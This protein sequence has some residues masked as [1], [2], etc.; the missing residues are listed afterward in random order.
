MSTEAL[1]AGC[2]G[3]VG[4]GI[5]L[6]RLLLK[7][8]VGVTV[9]RIGPRP[10]FVPPV[11]WNQAADEKTRKDVKAIVTAG[12][13]MARR[14]PIRSRDQAYREATFQV[15]HEI[16]R[17]NP[18]ARRFRVEEMAPLSSLRKTWQ[19]L[20]K[21]GHYTKSPFN[22]EREARVFLYFPNDSD[23]ATAAFLAI[24]AEHHPPNAKLGVTTRT[25][26]QRLLLGVATMIWQCQCLH[27]HHEN[28][29]VLRRIGP[30]ELPVIIS[31]RGMACGS[32]WDV[33]RR[34]FPG[35]ESLD[36][37]FDLYEKDM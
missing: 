29:E 28:S 10:K 27:W 21:Q 15:P 13:E 11:S 35:L 19:A 4:L 20:A 1:I 32:L 34:D 25:D 30:R 5:L 26:N 7:G 22:I 18:D 37:A 6:V 16:A 23:K 2:L 33:R 36:V 8:V 3:S 17:L 31:F 12:F 9:T 14:K 24:N